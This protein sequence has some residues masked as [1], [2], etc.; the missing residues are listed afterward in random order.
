MDNLRNEMIS[1]RK[2]C[3]ALMSQIELM[4]PGLADMHRVRIATP[5]D[6]F[7]ILQAVRSRAALRADFDYWFQVRGRVFFLHC[8]VARLTKSCR[9]CCNCALQ[10][11]TYDTHKIIDAV[12]RI[13]SMGSKVPVLRFDQVSLTLRMF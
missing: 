8:R 11:S 2:Q 1:M 6:F 4:H 10:S 3:R 12:L 9:G 5:I 13:R 7:Y